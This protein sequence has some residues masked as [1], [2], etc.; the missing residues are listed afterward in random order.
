MGAWDLVGMYGSRGRIFPGEPSHAHESPLTG[1]APGM[2]RNQRI[3]RG[4]KYFPVK[5]VIFRSSPSIGETV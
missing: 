2:A 3:T 4:H 5:T 1:A